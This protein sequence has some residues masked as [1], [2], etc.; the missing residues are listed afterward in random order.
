MGLFFFFL[1]RNKLPHMK[2][3]MQCF[4]NFLNF[5][6]LNREVIFLV[7][8][9]DSPLETSLKWWGWRLKLGMS[10]RLRGTMCD[11][12]KSL[13]ITLMV[14]G[15]WLI[16]RI[17]AAVDY[18]LKSNY[19]NILLGM[20][21]NQDFQWSLLNCRFPNPSSQKWGSQ[22]VLTELKNDCIKCWL[23]HCKV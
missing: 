12:C 4:S 5:S 19:W 9:R 23:S 20:G 16:L 3:T 14:P 11:V 17:T 8:V 7:S 6:C 22:E 15:F 21:L 1:R 18:K 2:S 10:W 13:Q